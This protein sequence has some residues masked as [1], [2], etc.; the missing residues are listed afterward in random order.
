VP[1]EDTVG[2][3]AEMVKVGYVRHIGLSEVGADIIRAH[4]IHPVSDLQPQGC[5]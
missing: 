1:I 4:D 2:A 3:M 5:S